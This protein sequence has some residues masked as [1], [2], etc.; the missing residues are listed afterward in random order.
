MRSLGRRGVLI[1]RDV[2]AYAHAR[3]VTVPLRD[4]HTASTDVGEPL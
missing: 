4:W 3:I 1:I 2:L